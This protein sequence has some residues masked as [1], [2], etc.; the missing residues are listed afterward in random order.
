MIIG[1]IY[2]LLRHEERMLIEAIRKRG[3]DLKLSFVP[4][5]ID[6]L[7]SNSMR[8]EEIDFA[9]QRCVS[10]YRALAT[11]AIL[12][13]K[14]V[15]VVNSYDTIRDSG[16][17][18]VTTAKLI[19]SG[20]KTPKTAVVYSRSG[21]LLAA[22]E[23]GYPVVVKPI[24]GSWGRMIARARS[25]DDL[26]DI[27]DFREAMGSPQFK[28]H[29]IQQ[30]VDKPDRDIRAFYVWGEVPVSIYRIS[31]RWK[32]NTALGGKA[33]PANLTEEQVDLV[34]RASEALGGGVLGIDLLE[35][36]EGETLVGE[37]N[38]VI[39]FRNTVQVTGYDLAG[40]IVDETVRVMR[41]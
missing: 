1:L 23:L 5:K 39:E 38:G 11:S 20:L 31:Q 33:A 12:E 8:D 16:D 35:T 14:G 24:Q 32:T 9:F 26:L 34:I 30:F 22:R 2:D 27:M 15:R 40:K 4:E 7:D 3:H 37:V 41:R 21:A 18:L 17:K 29:Y 6:Y 25:E 13:S 10:H 19:R 36:R 28:I